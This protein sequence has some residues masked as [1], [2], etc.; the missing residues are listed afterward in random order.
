M[1]SEIAE[2]L[3]DAVDEGSISISKLRQVLAA[4]LLWTGKERLSK[5]QIILAVEAFW[6][7]EQSDVERAVTRANILR[8]IGLRAVPVVAA[9]EWALGIADMAHAEGAATTSNGRMDNA[10][11][12]SALKKVL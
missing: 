2:L 12:S 5:E 11:W 1:K 7:A 6:L 4:D 10:S 3:H 9:R 8:R